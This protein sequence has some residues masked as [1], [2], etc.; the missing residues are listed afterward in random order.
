MDRI[1]AR[2]K[3]ITEANRV[4]DVSLDRL[5]MRHIQQAVCIVRRRR[6]VKP[7]VLRAAGYRA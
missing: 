2:H 4:R 5:R 1:T 3:I 6:L 7:D